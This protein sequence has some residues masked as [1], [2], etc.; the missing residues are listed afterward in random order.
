MMDSK[1]II[2]LFADILY[3]KGVINLDELHGLYDI[4]CVADLNPFT[5]KMLRGEFNAYRKGEHY[6]SIAE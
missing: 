2:G 5:E 6:T 4:T 1:L 3:S